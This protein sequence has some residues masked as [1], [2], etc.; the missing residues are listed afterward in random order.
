MMNKQSYHYH[1]T[2]TFNL[3]VKVFQNYV[4]E[5]SAV[6]GCDKRL[7]KALKVL[8]RVTVGQSKCC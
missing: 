4:V 1:I 8:F 5:S 6:N 7:W 2:C 3:H